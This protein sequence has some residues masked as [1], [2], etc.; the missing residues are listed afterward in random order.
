MPL[1]WLEINN[2]LRGFAFKVELKWWMFAVPG[3]VL[4]TLALFVVMATTRRSATSNPVEAL[5]TE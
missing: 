3:I 5:R 4:M 2:W 1:A